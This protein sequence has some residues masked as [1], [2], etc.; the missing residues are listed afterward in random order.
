ML[1]LVAC[2]PLG[3]GLN[4]A[5]RLVAAARD[6]IGVTRT[7]DPGYAGLAYPGGDIPRV[8]GVCTDVVV[9]AYRDA[10]GLDLQSAVHE[11]MS[12]HFDAYPANWGLSA[13]DP[14]IDH[15]R[16]PN[17]ET[18]LRRRGLE[19]SARNWR[20]GDL[21]TCRIDG[22]LAHIA[23]ISDRP[24]RDGRWAA[25][26]NIGRG[27]EETALIGRFSSERRFRFP[28]LAA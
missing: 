26:H 1:A 7:Y 14:N 10:F 20:P 18:F 24:A 8:R 2:R 21:L 22:R 23:I 13:P 16:V 4:W 12:A 5:E 3:G 27:A 25:I 28:P 17:L 9:R 15:R 19:Y 11:D 6:Q